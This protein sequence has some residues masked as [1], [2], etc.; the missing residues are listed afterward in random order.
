MKM[1]EATV[2]LAMS[3]GFKNKYEVSIPGIGHQDFDGRKGDL[4]VHLN[5]KIPPDWVYDEVTGGLTYLK[6]EPIETFLP[7]LALPP[8]NVTSTER[9]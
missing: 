9:Y 1:K 7:F 4:I 8:D 5:Y 2:T 3:P 6:V